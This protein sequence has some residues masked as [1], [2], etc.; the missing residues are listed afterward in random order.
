MKNFPAQGPAPEAAQERFASEPSRRAGAGGSGSASTASKRRVCGPERRPAAAAES[1][2][3][4]PTGAESDAQQSSPDAQSSAQPL[5]GA[6]CAVSVDA[7][8]GS[9]GGGLSFDGV[10]TRCV[11]LGARYSGTVHKKVTVL[12]A[13]RGAARRRTQRVK[14]AAAPGLRRGARERV[15][16]RPNI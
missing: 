10:H 1:G 14:K 7:S 2:T 9:D 11:A 13:S 16:I 15:L 5:R 3:Q 4:Q 12:L 8:H 6:V